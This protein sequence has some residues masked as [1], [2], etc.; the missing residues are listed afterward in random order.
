MAAPREGVR[1][2]HAV[3]LR[4]DATRADE[5][6]LHRGQL[7]RRVDDLGEAGPGVPGGERPAD[8]RLHA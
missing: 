4:R 2:G 5:A 1:A 8:G 3:A 7:Q 6:I